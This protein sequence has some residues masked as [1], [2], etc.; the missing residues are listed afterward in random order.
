LLDP[1]A[2]CGVAHGPEGVRLKVLNPKFADMFAPDVYRK[3]KKDKFNLH[4]QYLK[5]SHKPVVYDYFLTVAGPCTLA[6]RYGQC[7]SVQGYAGLRGW[8]T[9]LAG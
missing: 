4:F 5:A 7:P 6:S 8:P 2:A 9:R 3:A 1:L